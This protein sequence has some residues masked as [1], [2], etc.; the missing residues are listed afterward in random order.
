MTPEEANP[1]QTVSRC[2]ESADGDIPNFQVPST[3]NSVF[4][5]VTREYPFLK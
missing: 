5:V 4:R 3:N 2:E 1:H